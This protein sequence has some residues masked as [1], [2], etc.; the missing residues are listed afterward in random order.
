MAASQDVTIRASSRARIP[1]AEVNANTDSR[2]SQES[3]VT[4]PS[5]INWVAK[6]NQTW[7]FTR[8]LLCADGGNV[9]TSHVVSLKLVMSERVEAMKTK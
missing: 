2:R 3:S 5:V 7:L 1:N 8:L 4:T 6:K 9:V